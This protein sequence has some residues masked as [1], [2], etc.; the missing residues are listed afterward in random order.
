M[1]KDYLVLGLMVIFAM[2][3]FSASTAALTANSTDNST[4]N[5]EV[6][7]QIMI[8]VSPAE[9]SW[10]GSDAINPGAVSSSGGNIGNGIWALEIENIGS[11]NVTAIWFNTTA[12]S[13]N[14]FGTGST[15]AYDAGQF[16]KISRTQ[17]GTYYYADKVEYNQSKVPIY[18][19][20]PA[21]TALSGRFRD[22][23]HEWFFAVVP[24]TDC[25]DG[26]L[27]VAGDTG[28]GTALASAHNESQ[29][30]DVDLTDGEAGH[31]ITSGVTNVTINGEAYDVVVPADCSKV[32]FKH[33]D[34]DVPGGAQVA[35]YFNTG[36]FTPGNLTEAYVKAYVPYGVHYGSVKTGYLTVLVTDQ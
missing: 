24:G 33:W 20:N 13:S 21:S 26:T 22:A 32:T 7:G 1:R 8:D 25:S 3:L 4:V 31:T 34:Y 14:P 12:E 30:G 28:S 9:L 27:Y 16:V 6:A 5:V 2:A 23:N 11:I 15:N 18:V 36:T 17:S 10:T 19:T 35:E 29:T